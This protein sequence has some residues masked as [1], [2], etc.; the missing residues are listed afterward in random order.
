[1]NTGAIAKP[2]GLKLLGYQDTEDLDRAMKEEQ[3]FDAQMGLMSKQVQAEQQAQ[4]Q[5]A[6]PAQAGMEQVQNNVANLQAGQ[7][8]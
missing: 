8:V 2:S 5:V 6:S 3:V 4:Q 1:M 7:V